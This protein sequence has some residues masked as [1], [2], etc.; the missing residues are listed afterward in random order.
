MSVQTYRVK[1]QTK[2]V[3]DGWEGLLTLHDSGEIAVS[4]DHRRIFDDLEY[5][6]EGSYW[7]IKKP[8]TK[9]RGIIWDRLFDYTP[10]LDLN[11]NRQ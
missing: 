2:F 8:T 6:D 5:K 7:A 10:P 9:E 1:A 3:R 11:L 4:V